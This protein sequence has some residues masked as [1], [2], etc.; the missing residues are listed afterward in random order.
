MNTLKNEVIISQNIPQ[1]LR[2]IVWKIAQKYDEFYISNENYNKVGAD[3]TLIPY[4]GDPGLSRTSWEAYAGAGK[5]ESISV[6]IAEEIALE[7]TKIY[8]PTQ[9]DFYLDYRCNYSCPMCLFHG[10]LQDLNYWKNRQNLKQ[11]VPLELAK[12]RLDRLKNYGAT[13]INISYAGEPLLYPHLFPLLEYAKELELQISITTNGSLLTEELAKK[14]A[15]TGVISSITVSNSAFTSETYAKIHSSKKEDIINA[16][17]APF[18]LK[19]YDIPVHINFIEQEENKHEVEPFIEKFKNTAIDSFSVVPM[20]IFHND[21]PIIHDEPFSPFFCSHWF[22]CENDGTLLF[23]CGLQN[24][25]DDT[26]SLELNL[27][28]IDEEK[29]ITQVTF[30]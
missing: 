28:N 3:C 1:I 14:L 19:K 16:L 12:N 18:I 15:D 13:T 5:K 4:I 10:T 21:S 11:T 25:I 27:P 8:I 29:D 24:L 26:D 23:C 6:E 9:W 17:N 30:F 2:P 22:T 7:L 20:F